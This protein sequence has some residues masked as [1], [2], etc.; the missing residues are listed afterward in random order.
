MFKAGKR[1]FEARYRKIVQASAF[2]D[3]LVTAP[4]ATPWTFAW[5]HGLLGQLA[6][7]AP[8]EPIHVLFA[9]MMASLILVWSV[10][11]LRHPH[12]VFGLYDSLTRFLFLV[13]ELY[14]LLFLGVSPVL[15]MFAAFEFVWLVI[16]LV[17]YLILRRKIGKSII[18]PI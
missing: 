4:F 6:P 11:R 1:M 5:T 2:Y 15:W 13:W 18:L 8:F 10:L 14:F 3:V 16:Q 7:L 12:P 9:N 17:G